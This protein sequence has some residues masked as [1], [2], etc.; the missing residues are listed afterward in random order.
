MEAALP[1]MR[2]LMGSTAD[3]DVPTFSHP[4]PADL[5]GGE[6]LAAQA[7]SSSIVVLTSRL[8]HQQLEVMR[9]TEEN[10]R[11]RRQ[12]EAQVRSM[13]PAGLSPCPSF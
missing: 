6:G 12:L 2:S 4:E 1:D 3:V 8:Q 11:L 5:S 10:E 7:A 9:L 13:R